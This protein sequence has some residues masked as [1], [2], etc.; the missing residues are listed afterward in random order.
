[1]LKR[2]AW[3]GLAVLALLIAVWVFAGLRSVG[4]EGYAVADAVWL[5]GDPELLSP[6][7]HFVAPGVRRIYRYPSDPQITDLSQRPVEWQTPEGARL[8]FRAG[9]AYLIR[10]DGVLEVHRQARG[11]PLEE[12]IVRPAVQQV[13]ERLAGDPGAPSPGTAG[14]L[15]K[16]EE[17]LGAALAARGIELTALRDVDELSAE[18][19]TVLAEVPQ[20]NLLVFGLDGADWDIIDPLIERGELPHLAR[21]ART[22]ARA[23]LR[24]VAPILSPVVWT[25]VATGKA[26]AKHGILDFLASSADGSMVPVTS[27]LWQ[28]R[29][30]WSILGDAGVPVAVTAWWATW[31]AQPVNGYLASDRIAYQLFKE[32]IGPDDPAGEQGRGKTWPRELFDEI[33]PLI[34]QPAVITD[35]ELARFIDLDP[36]GPADDDDTQRLNELRTVLAS[37]R[38]YEAIATELLRRQPR[39]FHAVYTEA[40]DTAAHLFMPFRPP[41]RAGVDGRHAAAFGGVVDAI[42]REA[43]AM[44]G[45]VLELLGPDWNVL[46]LSDH[47]FRHGENRPAT[48][49]RIG[50]GPAADWHDRFGVL[51]LHGPD[52]RQGVTV[53][54]AT[55]L[56]IAPTVLALYGLPLGEDMDGRALEEAIAPSFLDAHPIRRIP[57]YEG[58]GPTELAAIAPSSQDADL[59]EKLRAL[60]YIGGG[61]EPAAPDSQP[62]GPS[63][64]DEFFQDSARAHNNRGI[65]LMTGGDLDGALAEFEKGLAAGGGLQSLVNLVHVHLLKGNLDQ[66]ERTLRRLEA[67]SPNH[68]M[69]PGLRGRLADRRGDRAAAERFLREAI[70]RDPADSR[71]HTRLGHLLEE[72]GDLDQALRHYRAAVRANPDNAEAHNY[73]G[74]V[75]RLQQ[76]LNGAEAAYREAVRADPKY[77]GGYNNLGLLLQESG[78]LDEAIELYRKG[79]EQAP[80]SALLN[81]SL[82]SLLIVRGR[83]DEAEAAAERALEIDPRMAEALNNRGILRALQGRPEEAR[84][85][86]EEALAVDPH[87]VDAN[88]NL[89]KLLLTGREVERALEYFARTVEL[90]PRHLPAALG[91]GETAYRLGLDDRAIF[92]FEHSKTIKPGIARVHRTLGELYLK[93]GDPRKA[94]EEWRESLKLSPDQPEL[95]RRLQEIEK[96]RGHSGFLP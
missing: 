78:R 43:D 36:L 17:Q 55:V 95:R 26:P 6:G 60:G 93:R 33:A 5:R 47:G 1:M 56:D 86:F 9:L 88:F 48:D 94:I 3:I 35:G 34:V 16:I 32:L 31:P 96:E 7:R 92:Y 42:Y 69:I 71:S 80:R 37:S 73:M 44:V 13:L 67:E 28:A 75:L 19:P 29:A 53:A 81:N 40:T 82:A 54:D 27:T 77:P 11:E 74:N 76:D 14:F 70:R 41:L 39:G 24:T 4:D 57:S 79:L 68:R 66:A 18:R 87:N 91:A 20:R 22:G 61:T 15:A 45:R 21:L 10:P 62:D 23:R 63:P 2:S 51:I 85:S 90:D 30:L 50:H 52:I 84:R 25:S 59:I 12:R 83:L 72:S 89:A 46:I 38:T 65:A 58:A 64:G 8:E 49:P